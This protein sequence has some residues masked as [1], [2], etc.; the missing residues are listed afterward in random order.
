MAE[1]SLGEWR[2]F[3]DQAVRKITCTTGNPNGK[4]VIWL[5]HINVAD[6]IFDLDF[7]VVIRLQKRVECC[8]FPPGRNPQS[9]SAF[10]HAPHLLL[11][12]APTKCRMYRV[13]P[14]ACRSAVANA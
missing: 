3:R 9:Y 8:G 7:D 1:Q 5:L 2:I 6:N 12:R 13:Q 14:R 11:P 10:R 4:E